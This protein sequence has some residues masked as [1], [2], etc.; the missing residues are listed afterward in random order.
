MRKVARR[1]FP[2]LN[3]KQ[4]LIRSRNHNRTRQIAWGATLVSNRESAELLQVWQ[5]A[6][7]QHFN[8]LVVKQ[9]V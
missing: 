9:R 7:L 1:L 3:K 8:N 5:Q 2:E 4:W 6:L